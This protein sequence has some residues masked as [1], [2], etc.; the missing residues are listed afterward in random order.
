MVGNDVHHGSYG[1]QTSCAEPQKNRNHLSADQSLRQQVLAH[2][3]VLKLPKK[4]RALVSDPETREDL[5]SACRGAAH[6][7]S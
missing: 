1:V 6:T 3:F 7:R 2:A 4:C 5:C